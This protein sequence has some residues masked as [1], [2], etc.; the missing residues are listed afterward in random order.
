M[1]LPY[2]RCDDNGEKGKLADREPGMGTPVFL[3]PWLIEIPGQAF[4]PIESELQL[5]H[6]GFEGLQAL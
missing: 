2:P 1:A 4:P 6:V 5:W 3:K